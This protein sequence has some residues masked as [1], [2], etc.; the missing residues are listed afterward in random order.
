VPGVGRDL[1]LLRT[2]V[3]IDGQA[4]AVQAPPPRLGEHTQAILHELGFTPEEIA[5]LRQQ[6]A[7]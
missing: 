1:Q 2:G 3:K 4:L 5:D 6:Q 7:I